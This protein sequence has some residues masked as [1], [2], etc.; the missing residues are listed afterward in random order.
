MKW[1]GGSWRVNQM[2]KG[3]AT[4]L[5]SYSFLLRDG[6]RAKFPPVAYFIL[7]DQRMLTTAPDAFPG[8]E[9]VPGPDPGATWAVFESTHAE[10]WKDVQQGVL[11]AR[12]LPDE[13]GNDPPRET[14]VVDERLVFE[15]PCR[16]CDFG[17]LC[18]R[19]LAGG[20]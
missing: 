12:G 5:A 2:A 10:H 14:R 11:R 18:G 1:G 9:A 16:W 7:S 8:A 15:P 4:Q 6:A 3:T 13:R 19:D 17:A 20:E